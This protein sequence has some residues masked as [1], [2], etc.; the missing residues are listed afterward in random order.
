VP[1]TPSNS[2]NSAAL[3]K[4][5]YPEVLSTSA[6]YSGNPVVAAAGHAPVAGAFQTA[7]NYFSAN[8]GPT[9]PDYNT[10]PAQTCGKKYV[11]F[12]TF[13]QPTKGTGGNVYPPLGSAAATTFGVTSVTSSNIT[14]S[15]TNNA[16]VTEAITKIQSLYNGGV[17][18]YV[19]GVGS[20]VNPDISGTTA[21]QQAVAQQGQYVL[22]AM[23][24]A[25]GTNTLYTATSSSQLQSALNTIVANILGKSVVSSYAAPPSVTVGSLEFF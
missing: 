22:Q 8:S 10:H 2:T 24:N 4:A 1:I 13:G 20:A 18:T 9:N 15:S 5:I 12:I 11:I 14:S 19:I 3:L 25:G 7:I 6:S 23:A 16:A 21:Q 17:K